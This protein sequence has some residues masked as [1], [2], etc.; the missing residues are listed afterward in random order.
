MLADCLNIKFY[1]YFTFKHVI[2][3]IS[4][5]DENFMNTSI[6]NRPTIHIS[7]ARAFVKRWCYI[8]MIVVGT[9]L[10][11]LKTPSNM[12]N[13]KLRIHQLFLLHY[14]NKTWILSSNSL[15]LYFWCDMTA[16][17]S[18]YIYICNSTMDHIRSKIIIILLYNYNDDDDDDAYWRAKF[19]EFHSAQNI[20]QQAIN[21]CLSELFIMIFK[22]FSGNIWYVLIWKSVY[23]KYAHVYERN[24]RSPLKLIQ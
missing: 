12:I 13:H 17:L 7:R 2:K 6:E 9:L 1:I 20:T 22:Y 21:S 15:S 4:N 24:M 11:N 19:A 23:F 3:L 10:G 5:F 18:E 8:I 14:M 16:V